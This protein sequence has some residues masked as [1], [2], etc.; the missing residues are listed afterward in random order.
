MMPSMLICTVCMCAVMYVRL[1]VLVC[2]SVNVGFC[3]YIIM[4]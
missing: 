2:L 4:K 1:Y 3:V